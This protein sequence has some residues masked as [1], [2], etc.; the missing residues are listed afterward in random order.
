MC[1]CICIIYHIFVYQLI[2]WLI[3]GY[4]YLLTIVYS[5]A[6][7]VGV[8]VSD[9]CFQF[10]WVYIYLGVELLDHMIIL[11]LFLESAKLVSSLSFLS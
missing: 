7:N 8:Q 1:G 4:F 6:V 3:H 9:P 2:C 11:G 10:Y 5:V